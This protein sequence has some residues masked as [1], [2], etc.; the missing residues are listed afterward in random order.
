MDLTPPQPRVG[1]VFRTVIRSCDYGHRTEK[2]YWYWIGYFIR[3]HG[4][5]QAEAMRATELR[6]FLRWLTMERDVATSTQKI[7]GQ[8]SGC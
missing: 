4:M 3:F 8:I 1:R 2:A 7:C 5:R 6:R